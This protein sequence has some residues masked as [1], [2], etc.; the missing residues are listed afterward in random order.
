MLLVHPQ[1]WTVQEV[2]TGR[3]QSE[4]VNV[5]NDCLFWKNSNE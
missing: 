3:I 2:Q 5:L 1:V 4:E